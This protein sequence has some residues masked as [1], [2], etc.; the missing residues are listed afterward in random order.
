MTNSTT[1]P[2]ETFKSFFSKD[3]KDQLYFH[4]L[5]KLL[6]WTDS[7]L[8]KYTTLRFITFRCFPDGTRIP[9][10][11]ISKKARLKLKRSL[12]SNEPHPSLP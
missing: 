7:K 1:L 5:V 2:T 6:T 8:I 10:I 4:K 12:Q 11:R 3:S 9:R